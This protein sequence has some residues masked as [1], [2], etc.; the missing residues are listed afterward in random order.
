VEK[1]GVVGDDDEEA[2]GFLESA[3]DHG[4]ATFEDAVDSAAG[5]VRFGRAAAA[6]GGSSSPIDAGYDEVAVEGGACVFGGDVKVR[7]SIGRNDEGKA[8][9]VELDGACDEVGIEG[10]DVVGMS[11]AGDAPLFFQSEESP[12]DRRKGDAES[13]G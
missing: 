13:F 1:A 5:A 9:R 8:F 10:S 7:R 3:D 12:R 2:S 4:G 11:D 6:G